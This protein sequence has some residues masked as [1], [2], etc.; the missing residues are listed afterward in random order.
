MKTLILRGINKKVNKFI[1][2]FY[3]QC[4]KMFPDGDGKAYEIID[5][6]E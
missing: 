2:V 5:K 3:K 1:D 6:E 4:K